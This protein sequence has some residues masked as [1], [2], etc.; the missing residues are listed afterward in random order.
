MILSALQVHDFIGAVLE[1]ILI[2]ACVVAFLA[3]AITGFI[4]WTEGPGYEAA[5]DVIGSQYVKEGKWDFSQGDENSI[6]ESWN[7]IPFEEKK[8]LIGEPDYEPAIDDASEEEGPDDFP[9]E[10]AND[11]PMIEFSVPDYTILKGVAGPKILK[12]KI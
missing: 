11:A 12:P 2:L 1:L 9:E 3:V 6:H 4:Y 8:R 10:P 5:L 7:Q